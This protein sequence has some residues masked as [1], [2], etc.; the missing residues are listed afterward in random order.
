MR[1][2]LWIALLAVTLPACDQ[3][4]DAVDE[5]A[6]RA[7][8]YADAGTVRATVDGDTFSGT[9]VRVEAQAGTLTVIGADNVV[10]Q[11]DQEAITLTFRSTAP[12]PYD[13]E[14]AD[15]AASIA[16]RTE[17][18]DDQADEVYVGLEGTLTL[19]AYT[20]AAASGGF[21]FTARNAA[22]DLVTVT[23]GTFDVTF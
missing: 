4:S 17:S 5:A 7:S 11:N 19:D 12:G 2:A 22:G 10:S 9:C 23:D 8:G 13:V 1:H 3:V 15:A 6:C 20:E 18:Q 21:S 14:E 16:F